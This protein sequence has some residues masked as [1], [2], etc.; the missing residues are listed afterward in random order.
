MSVTDATEVAGHA[1]HA[2]FFRALGDS[3]RLAILEHLLVRPHNVSEL[4]RELGVSQSK[5]SNHLACLRWCRFVTAERDGRQV[6]Y[7]VSD[8]RLRGL[9]DLATELACESGEHLASCRRI[10]PDWI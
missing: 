2:R 1:A 7:T 5:V 4:I 3:T 6:I 10:G 8:P 9:L